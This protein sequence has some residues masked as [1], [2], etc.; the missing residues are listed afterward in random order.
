MKSSLWM[1]RYLIQLP[2]IDANRVGVYGKVRASFIKTY[3][4]FAVSCYNCYNISFFQAYGGFLSTL[5]VLSHSSVFRCGIAVA[6]ITDWRLYG[7][8]IPVSDRNTRPTGPAFGRH[9]WHGF[10]CVNYN[11]NGISALLTV[12]FFFFPLK[13]QP[14]LRNTLDIQQKRITN[15]RC[16]CMSVVFLGWR[17]S[18]L[19]AIIHAYC[20]HYYNTKYRNAEGRHTAHAQETTG[21]KRPRWK[22]LLAC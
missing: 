6:P 3:I 10:M 17:F 15:T 9:G 20:W 8:L 7:K 5:L 21:A 14:S 16:G 4:S 22:E 12:F 11:S 1:L 18:L 19:L 2:Y 13:A